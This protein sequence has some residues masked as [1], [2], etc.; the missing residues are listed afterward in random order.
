[1]TDIEKNNVHDLLFKEMQLEPQ[2]LSTYDEGYL[3]DTMEMQAL[4][5][6]YRDMMPFISA[7]S[8]GKKELSVL[9]K[10]INANA[11]WLIGFL[12]ERS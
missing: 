7:D 9:K 10:T 5:D 3:F 2:Q 4:L 8:L 1:M 12:T 11:N 6:G